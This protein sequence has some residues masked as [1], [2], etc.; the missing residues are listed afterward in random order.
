MNPMQPMKLPKNRL[1]SG[2]IIA[3]ALAGALVG[4]RAVASDDNYTVSI[5]GDTAHV[6]PPPPPPPP[7]HS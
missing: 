7:G 1:L 4:N 5:S 6:P 3:L 2:V